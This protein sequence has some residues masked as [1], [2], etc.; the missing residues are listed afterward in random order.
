MVARPGISI[1]CFKV[2][3]Y[4]L[5]KQLLINIDQ[6]IPTP[7]AKEL[8]IGIKAKEAEE[9]STK[10]LQKKRD[11]IR[12]EYWEQALESFRKSQCSIYNNISPGNDSY[13]SA[14]SGVSG[15]VYNLIFKKEELRVELGIARS[16]T[17]ENK[18]I[19][20][21]LKAMKDEIETEFGE[22]LEWLRLDDKETI[23]HPVS[24]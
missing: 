10:I 11:T 19:F 22:A 17:E 20:D 2:T 3:S 13:I 14:G 15:C 7:E 18:S 12:R 16:V 4:A 9:K 21:F 5:G 24:L 23:T 8:M 6:I 1:Q